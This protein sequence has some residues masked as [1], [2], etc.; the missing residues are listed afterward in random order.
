MNPNI[1][2]NISNFKAGLDNLFPSPE[3]LK[4]DTH[5]IDDEIAQYFYE[6]NDYN[7]AFD[8]QFLKGIQQLE[9]EISTYE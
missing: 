2:N 4:T 7:N 5:I 9:C 3:T 8:K 1:T 6:I